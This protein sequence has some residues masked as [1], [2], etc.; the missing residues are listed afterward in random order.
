MVTARE[1][2][3]SPAEC[4]NERDTVQE[5]ARMMKELQVGMLPICGTD[6]RLAGTITDRD[7]VVN[8]VAEGMDTSSTKVSEYAQ[9]KP[10]TI[11]ANDSVEE[12]IRTMQ[13]HQVRRLPVIDGHSLVGMLAQ[14]D[15][16][17]FYDKNSTGE[18]V[19]GIS[20]D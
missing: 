7:I 9:G 15:I 5:A 4:V 17:R 14:A 20:R 6:E 13:K 2:M 12:A 10:V 16:A 1:L 19:E 18:L 8:C 11:G 3:T